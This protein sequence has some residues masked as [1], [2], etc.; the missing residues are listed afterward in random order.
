M[1]MPGETGP[2][3]GQGQEPQHDED[4]S[5]S[6]PHDAPPPP[7]SEFCGGRA[8]EQQRGCGAQPECEHDQGAGTGTAAG[9]RERHRTVDESAGKRAPEEACTDGARRC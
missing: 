9:R 7:G 4:Q 1:R 6:T 5:C 2:G 3:K 8:G